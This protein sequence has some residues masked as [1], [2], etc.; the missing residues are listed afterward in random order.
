MSVGPIDQYYGQ[1]GHAI[2][3]VLSKTIENAT[4]INH[5]SFGKAEIKLLPVLGAIL[6]KMIGELVDGHSYVLI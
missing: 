2:V 4:E 6:K 1:A 5:L 3:L